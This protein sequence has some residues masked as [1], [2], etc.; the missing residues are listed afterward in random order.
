MDE[1]AYL[2][3]RRSS[4][5][6]APAAPTPRWWDAA[7]L[8][9]AGLWLAALA[10]GLWFLTRIE[11]TLTVFCL[12]WLIAYLMNPLVSR[13]QGGR[14]GPVKH[15]PR[16]LA[17]AT[18]YFC[19]L[20]AFVLVGSLL[21]P[22]IAGQVD[23][24]MEIQQA[25]YNPH[26]LAVTV[27]DQGEKLVGMVPQQ[28]RAQLLDKLRASIGSI[29]QEI[30]QAVGFGVSRLASFFGQIVAGAV[31]FLS[32][33]LISV[34]MVLSWSAMGAGF[35]GW[36]PLSYQEDV[37]RL[38]ERM[39]KIF[40][41]YLRATILTSCAAGVC[42]TLGLWLFTVV[43]GQAVPYLQVIGLIAGLLY[44]IPLFGILSSSIAGGVLAFLPENDLSTSIWVTGIVFSVMV[45][46]DRT[47]LPKLMSDAI[48]VSPLFVIFAAAAG[49]EFLGG[50]WGMLLGIP[51][52]AMMKAL[53]EWVHDRFMIDPAQRQLRRSTDRPPP[54]PDLTELADTAPEDADL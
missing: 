25:I 30:G 8:V 53:F 24:L 42:T 26:Q 31:I 1:A 3:E 37:V 11:F 35:I 32:A 28:Y 12:A 45:V 7:V 51:L 22:T 27:Q 5:E 44:P 34:Y 10:L 43:S 47:L 48:G 16:G 9:R 36:F 13:L 49:G 39:N 40:G 20:A 52:A 23:R 41:G 54:P 38:L 50:V 6:P 21:F 2:P 46:V 19:I 15:C 18:I 4:G 29:T 17:V 33:L 14:L